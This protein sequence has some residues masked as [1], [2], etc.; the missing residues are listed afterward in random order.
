MSLNNIKITALGAA[1]AVVGLLGSCTEENGPLV[2]EYTPILF[3]ASGIDLDKGHL[4]AKT[5]LPAEG[6]SF[7][8]SPVL[9]EEKGYVIECY[10][11]RQCVDIQPP[12]CRYQP[13]ETHGPNGY[14]EITYIYGGEVCSELPERLSENLVMDFTV[15]QNDSDKPR[16]IR[17]SISA[18]FLESL[19]LEIVQEAASAS[20]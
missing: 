18:G 6:G 15:N 2:D 7:S 9:S 3:E 8:I 12:S 13:Y 10:A 14:V 17:V 4:Y 20:N 11:D 1:L 16:Y 5:T 19:T